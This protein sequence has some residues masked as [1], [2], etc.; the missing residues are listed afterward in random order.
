[1]PSILDVEV[2]VVETRAGLGYGYIF[3]PAQS[4]DTLPYL[5]AGAMVGGSV[6]GSHV[7]IPYRAGEDTAHADA[8]RVHSLIV[9]GRVALGG[10]D[11]CRRSTGAMT[12]PR[13][14]R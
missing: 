1:M 6:A 3:I 9:A 10:L 2:G 13:A 12:A 4:A 14:T 11:V 8:A 5:V 7:S